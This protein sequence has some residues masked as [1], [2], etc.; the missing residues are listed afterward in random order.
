MYPGGSVTA[1]N[2]N[3]RA[4]GKY[5]HIVMTSQPGANNFKLFL[6]GIELKNSTGYSAQA[7]ANN[8][9]I[10]RRGSGS[11]FYFNGSIDEVRIYN[12]SLSADEIKMHYQSEFQRYSSNEWRFYNNIT[13]L[14]N[15]AYTY[16]GWANDTAGNSNSSEVRTLSI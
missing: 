13:N 8:L 16:Y 12:R 14:A 10:G 11:S 1:S 15:G 7:S 9:N 4:D 5:H 2:T 6:D 3:I